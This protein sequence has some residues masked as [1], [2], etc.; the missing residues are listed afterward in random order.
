MVVSGQS[1]ALAALPWKK[2]H[3]PLNGM[4]LGPSTGLDGCR[5]S[6]PHRDLIPGLYSL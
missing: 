3:C 1:L 5:K 2:I 4:L 6:F